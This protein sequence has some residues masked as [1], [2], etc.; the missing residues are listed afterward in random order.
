MSYT[1]LTFGRHAGK[2]LPQVSF[3]DADWLFWAWS[4]GV[5]G[6]EGPLYEEARKVVFRAQ[7]IKIPVGADGRK[8]VGVY[9]LQEVKTKTKFV[10]LELVAEEDARPSRGSSCS[11]GQSSTSGSRV[12]SAHTTSSATR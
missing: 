10:T 12:P 6:T 11:R 2:N 7:S 1:L 4:S 8:R 3:T 5:F 9:H